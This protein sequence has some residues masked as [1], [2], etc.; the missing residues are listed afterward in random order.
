VTQGAVLTILRD[1]LF[2]GLILS[3]PLLLASVIVGLIISVIQAATQVNEQTITFVPK[4]I[5]IAL[6]LIALG[7]WMMSRLADFMNR[8]MIDILTYIK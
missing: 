7:P 8:I 5:A 6:V 1:A 4:V 3:A 2:T